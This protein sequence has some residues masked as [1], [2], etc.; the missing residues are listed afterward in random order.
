VLIDPAEGM[1]PSAANSL[2]K[3]LEEPAPRTHL[4]LLCDSPSRLLPTLLSRCEQI[5]LRLPEREQAEQWLARH[6]A[7][8]DPDALEVAGGSPVRALS[9]L[10]KDA[11]GHFER[12]ATAISDAARPGA[13]IPDVVARLDDIGAENVLRLASLYLLDFSRALLAGA[14][15]SRIR[16]ARESY[17]TLIDSVPSRHVAHTWGRAQAAL[18][19]LASGSNPNPRLQLEAFLMDWQAG[20]I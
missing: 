7:G 2:L 9:M 12:V 18:R 11:L 5:R 4:I 3:S 1:N 15:A 13:W 17:A 10:Q 16:R 8:K 19:D 14:T 20:C 6:A